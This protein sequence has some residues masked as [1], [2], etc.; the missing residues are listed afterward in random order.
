MAYDPL[1]PPGLI[2][3]RVGIKANAGSVWAYS[4][5]DDLAAV[6]A[7]DYIADGGDHGMAF[8]DVVHVYDRLN[9]VTSVCFVKSY[10][11]QAVT[12]VVVA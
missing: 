8:G 2:A 1:N 10:N 5:D 7:A 3:Q 12:L 6:L 9:V 4:S 11:D